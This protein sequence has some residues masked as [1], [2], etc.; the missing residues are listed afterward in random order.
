MHAFGERRLDTALFKEQLPVTIQ[1]WGVT[2]IQSTAS[3]FT[4]E[5]IA[6]EMLIHVSLKSAWETGLELGSPEC[7]PRSFNQAVGYSL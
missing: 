3:H 1:V 4:D 6:L 5:A 7:Q 2:R